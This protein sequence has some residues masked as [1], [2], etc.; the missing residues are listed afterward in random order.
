MPWASCLTA[1]VC[2]G[3]QASFWGA[4]QGCSGR[5]PSIWPLPVVQVWAQPLPMSLNASPGLP[6]PHAPTLLPGPLPGAPFPAQAGFSCHPKN[7]SLPMQS[8][9]FCG[10]WRSH[11]NWQSQSDRV[12]LAG[13]TTVLPWAVA[14][15]TMK[16]PSP[17]LWWQGRDVPARIDCI[18][19]LGECS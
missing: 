18:A 13:P 12:T 2:P 16:G 14:G 4:L 8:L 3:R 10:P 6:C 17:C 5:G 15:G 1:V 11:R 9:P 7:F 19:L